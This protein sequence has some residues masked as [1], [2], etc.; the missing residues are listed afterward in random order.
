M[1]YGLAEIED[2]LIATL[3]AEA[4]LVGINNIKSH[5]SDVNRLTFVDPAMGEGYVSLLPFI[6]VQY[7]G[8]SSSAN[9]DM[10]DSSG[11]LYSHRLYFR[12]YVGAQ[13]LRNAQEGQRSAYD[14]LAGVFDALHGKIPNCTAFAYDGFTK[15][16]GP[17][18]TRPE[19][20][21]IT[22]LIEADGTDEKLIVN[23][24]SI[25]VYQTDYHVTMVA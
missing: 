16:S 7:Q 9:A 22:P 11:T 13:C 25:V 18:I 2:Q 14:M 20:H 1:R 10:R 19:A 15:L 8:R 12:F 5:A 3:Q 24:P 4:S 17:E 6:F 21:P 23:L